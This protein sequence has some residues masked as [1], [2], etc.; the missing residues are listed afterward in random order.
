[1]LGISS[2]NSLHNRQIVKVFRICSSVV[3]RRNLSVSTGDSSIRVRTEPTNRWYN[4]G[5]RCASVD[6]S[7]IILRYN[8]KNISTMCKRLT[9]NI[10]T[11]QTH[12]LVNVHLV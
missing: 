3:V 12:I 10:V 6:S 8:I 5:G 9:L 11:T 4:L 2:C 1:L 7:V